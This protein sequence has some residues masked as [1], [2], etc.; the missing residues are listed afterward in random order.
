MAFGASHCYNAIWVNTMN[1]HDKTNAG[2]DDTLEDALEDLG[3]SMVRFM[4]KA[5]EKGEEIFSS[6]GLDDLFS[7]PPSQRRKKDQTSTKRREPVVDIFDE[8]DEVVIYVELPGVEEDTI[9]VQVHK[10]TLSVSGASGRET[11]VK[12]IDL[13]AGVQGKPKHHFKNGILKIQLKKRKT[14]TKSA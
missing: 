12:E 1:D 5:V 11:F 4:K 3:K 2:Q 9:E 14:G 7:A 6:G 13:P 8:G 10:G